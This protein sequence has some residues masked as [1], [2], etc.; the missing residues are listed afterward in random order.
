[1]HPAGLDPIVAFYSA[2]GRDDAGRS[3]D[4]ILAWDD[5]RLELVHDYIQWVFPTT[6]R[7]GVNPGA[8]LVT[9]A[10]VRAFA[11]QPELQGRLRRALARML[12]FYGL[13]RSG[14]RIE[15][16]ADRFS[17]RART[18]L[19]AGNHNHLR[20]TRIIDSLAALGLRRTRGRCS[21]ACSKTSRRRQAIGSRAARWSSGAGLAILETPVRPGVPAAIL[22][23]A[24]SATSRQREQDGTCAAGP[25]REQPHF[26]LGAK[27]ERH[28]EAPARERGAPFAATRLATA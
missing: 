24:G 17:A 4:E 28:G 10:T 26:V 19:H 11:E 13:R 3:L 8:P 14:D 23:Q 25:V 6:A 9:S 5:E 22:P 20:L 15:V 18:W 21:A 12:A 1:M 16:D 7:S 2:G 27:K